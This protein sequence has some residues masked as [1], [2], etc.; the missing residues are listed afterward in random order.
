[1]NGSHCAEEGLWGKNPAG[2]ENGQESSTLG[3]Q[4]QEPK[5]L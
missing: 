1:M 5:G 3:G 4:R 2:L